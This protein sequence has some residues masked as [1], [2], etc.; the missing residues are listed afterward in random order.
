MLIIV[1]AG[2][3]GS[4]K[5]TF[6]DKMNTTNFKNF[7]SPDMIA[8][9]PDFLSIADENDRI[10]AAMKHA[11]EMRNIII[12]NG[13]DLV[14]ET[15]FS[16]PSKLD[17]LQK[18]K[19]R[20][21]KIESIYVTTK[22][23]DINYERVQNRV[24]SGGHNV[25]K[26][27]IYNRYYRSLNLLC[28]IVSTSDYAKV[29]DNSY[30]DP[31]IVFLKEEDLYVFLNRENH[32]EWVAQYLIEPLIATNKIDLD[33]YS[34]SIEA[35]SIFLLRREMSAK[36]KDIFP[37]IEDV[38]EECLIEIFNKDAEVEDLLNLE[39]LFEIVENVKKIE[40]EYEHEI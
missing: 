20:G 25:P 19:D 8:L 15:V 9:E 40:D 13:E 36:Y 10:V 1:L 12:E 31:F 7:V 33:Y 17:F 35:T 28:E 37:E 22:D 14:F 27:K 38:S 16:H 26:E 32:E 11:E 21:Y 29:Y 39:T 4:G 30:E 2:P 34:L 6:F 23:P 24:N 3:N 18:A 5:T